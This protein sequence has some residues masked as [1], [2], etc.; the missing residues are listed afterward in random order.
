MCEAERKTGVSQ[1]SISRV[2]NGHNSHAGGFVWRYN[3]QSSSDGDSPFI[4][5][6]RDNNNNNNNN[7]NDNDN[8]DDDDD[9]ASKSAAFPPGPKSAPK[10][11]KERSC[12]KVGH[13]TT[14][15]VVQQFN[16]LTGFNNAMNIIIFLVYRLDNK[17]KVL[18]YLLLF[19]ISIV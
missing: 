16:L 4:G 7:N 14:P 3:V 6:S 8:D 17:C 10:L 13:S 18:F 11:I 9:S 1:S 2:C 19:L 15:R 12:V 5:H